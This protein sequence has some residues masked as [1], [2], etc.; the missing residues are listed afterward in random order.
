MAGTTTLDSQGSWY[1]VEKTIIH[2]NFQRNVVNDIGLLK[3]KNQ[4]EFN[5]KIS[6][7][8]L[9]KSN[10]PDGSVCVV[11]GWLYVNVRHTEL[12][13]NVARFGKI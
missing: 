1:E 13:E 9:P 12:L 3:I 8:S 6:A 10:T 4:I 2:D 7:I 11:S 5:D